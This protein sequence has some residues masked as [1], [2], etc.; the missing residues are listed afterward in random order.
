[1]E[2]DMEH[3]LTQ[4]KKVKLD[5]T[6]KLASSHF[7]VYHSYLEQTKSTAQYAPSSITLCLQTK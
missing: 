2:Q 7:P 3:N 1:M 4:E 6:G 5:N